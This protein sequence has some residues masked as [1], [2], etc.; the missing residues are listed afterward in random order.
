MS[1]VR[2]RRAVPA[3]SDSRLGETVSPPPDHNP[4]LIALV[5]AVTALPPGEQN[6][7]A[8]FLDTWTA[9]RSEQRAV[10][11][12]LLLPDLSDEMVAKVVGVAR[13]TLYTWP[14]YKRLKRILGALPAPPSGAVDGDGSIIEAYYR[15]EN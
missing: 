14:S 15:D 12:K 5:T 13:T 7:L 11:L 4:L 3:L 1:V 2:R 9:T 6:A 8:R 10:L